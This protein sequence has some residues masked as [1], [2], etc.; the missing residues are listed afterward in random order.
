MCFSERVSWAT[1]AVSMAGVGAVIARNQAS[2]ETRVLALALMVVGTM[3]LYEALLWRN[4]NNATVAKIA[5]LTNHLQ[6]V[7]FWA[8]CVLL[9]KPAYPELAPFAAAI[10]AA[11]IAV[12]LPYTT[13][14]W[15]DTTPERPLVVETNSGLEWKWN[16]YKG[17]TLVYGLFVVSACVTT[18]AYVSHPAPVIAAILA[19]FGASMYIYPDGMVGSMWCFYAALLPWLLLVATWNSP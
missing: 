17:K 7:V 9:L 18:L 6:P 3:Q 1:Y 10:L 4:P 13:R 8:L 12:V 5:M 2:T 16:R 11:Y 19:S 14:A 15:R